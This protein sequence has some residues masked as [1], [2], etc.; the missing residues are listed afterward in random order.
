MKWIVV[1]LV[2]LNISAWFLGKRIDPDVKQS[3]RAEQFETIN[4]VGMAVIEPAEEMLMRKE[5]EALALE[6]EKIAQL[7][8]DERGKVLMTPSASRKEPETPVIKPV[9][10]TA[11]PVKIVALDRKKLVVP[12]EPKPKP[13]KPKEAAV[14]EPVPT[15]TAPIQEPKTPEKIVLKCYRI[16]P[17]VDQS[18]FAN[19]RRTLNRNSIRY[20]VDERGAAK[21]IKAKRIYLGNFSSSAAMETEAKRLKQMKIDHYVLK[22]DGRTI[23]QL[24]YFSEP[25]RATAFQKTLKSRGVNASV[26]TIYHEAKVDS[27]LDVQQVSK[28]SL[29]ALKIPSSVTV[30]VRACP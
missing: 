7:K 20:T 17:F 23:I 4:G 10:E 16:G 3:P 30:K 18:N 24:G 21:K 9:V 6:E 5:N 15:P 14:S 19:V 22:S 29:K 2:L 26:E 27:W 1:I 11:N 12:A 13:V 25:A 8:L 28:D